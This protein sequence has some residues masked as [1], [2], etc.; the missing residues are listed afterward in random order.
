MSYGWLASNPLVKILA[1]PSGFE[2]ELKVLETFVLP[3]TLRAYI[4]LG[5]YNKNPALGERNLLSILFGF[6]EG[7][8]ILAT[9]TEFL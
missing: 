5:Y 9:L 1:G 7:L 8:M 3:L 2:P 6:F 4:S